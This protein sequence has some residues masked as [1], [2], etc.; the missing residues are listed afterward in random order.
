MQNLQSL[1]LSQA[2]TKIE[3]LTKALNRG[4]MESESSPKETFVKKAERKKSKKQDSNQPLPEDDL[5]L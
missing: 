1:T 3:T 5:L 2:E 4:P